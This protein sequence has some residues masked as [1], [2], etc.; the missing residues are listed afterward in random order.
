MKKILIFGLLAGIFVFMGCA[1]SVRPSSV[2]VSGPTGEVAVSEPVEVDLA[3]GAP[4][5]EA[6]PEIFYDGPF[7]VDGVS[8][9]YYDGAFFTIGGSGAYYFHHRVPFGERGFYH[10]HWNNGH[11]GHFERFHHDHPNYR[12]EHRGG[13]NRGPGIHHEPLHNTPRPAP[14]IH[15]RPAPAQRPAPQIHNRPAPQSAPARPAPRP[16]PQKKR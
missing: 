16:V 3:I 11:R 12:N 4:G 8:V 7:I 1:M 5:P 2:E 6:S 10:D 14:Q 9:F 13:I 15:N